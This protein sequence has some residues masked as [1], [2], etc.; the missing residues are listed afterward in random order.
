MRIALPPA[1]LPLGEV[2]QQINRDWLENPRVI[3]VLEKTRA[4]H[5]PWDKFRFQPLPA[6]S[7]ELLWHYARLQRDF[8]LQSLPLLDEQ[9]KPFRFLMPPGSGRLISQIDQQSAGSLLSEQSSLPARE[10]FVISSLMEEAISSSL[11]EGAQTTRVE[12]KK[13]L[14]EGRAPRNRAERMV[15]NNWATMEHI[16]TLKNQPLDMAMLLDIQAHMTRDTL[17]NAADSGRLRAR[18]DI[19]VVDTRN[20]EIVHRPPPFADLPA[21]LERLFAWAND[22]ESSW[23]HPVIKASILHFMIG[24]EHPF[25]D[26]NGRTARA[27]F[28]WFML[29][30][31]YWLFE[32]LAISRFF[33]RA[34]AQYGRAY[35]LSE[36][37]G[38]DVT[39]FLDYSLRVVE[40]SLHEMRAQVNEK[41]VAQG[42]QQA[43]PK[44][45]D[46]NARQNELLSHAA[47]NPNAQYSFALHQNLHRV[48]YQTARTD[49]LELE[50]RGYLKR[51]KQGKKFVFVPAQ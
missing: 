33:L 44:A 50:A 5:L 28:Y 27:L 8:S 13:M 51:Q 2:L 7:H 38:N 22:D 21:R 26:G 6:G 42:A 34:P 40:L 16:L 19:H 14:R 35:I 11:L 41:L 30:R 24:Y 4:A 25:V 45:P 36:T 32:F 49:L 10:R 47:R 3:E 1:P 23:I 39:Y 9:N 43:H 29:S 37:D 31:G 46:L 20:D 48:T 15:A 12:A 17:D 18:D